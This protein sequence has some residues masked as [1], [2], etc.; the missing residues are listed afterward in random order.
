MSGYIR[1]V[2]QSTKKD[3]V[4]GYGWRDDGEFYDGWFN[5]NPTWEDWPSQSLIDDVKEKAV[6]LPHLKF[7]IMTEV[8]TTQKKYME[9]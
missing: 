1:Y 6:S 5:H 7:R 9:I 3:D 8:K 4:N 2:V